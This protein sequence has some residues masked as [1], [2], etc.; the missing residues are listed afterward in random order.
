MS[1]GQN[2]PSLSLLKF[3]GHERD[4]WGAGESWDTLDYMHA[5]YASGTLGRFLSVDPGPLTV[6][7]PQSWNRY[8]YV[9]NSPLNYTDPSGR[10]PC[11]TSDPYI[12]GG[13]PFQSD[14][15]TVEAKADRVGYLRDI[16]FEF[17]FE[18]GPDRAF[19]M[20]MTF[21][22]KTSHV[23]RERIRCARIL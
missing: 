5:R 3:T 14:C 9:L 17:L 2:E 11:M 21:K 4:L 6:N 22:P 23:R 12:D 1:G 7:R 10:E 13:K 20:A 15:I 18:E 19:T 8:S 16:F